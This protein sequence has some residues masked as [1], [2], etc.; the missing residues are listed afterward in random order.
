MDILTLHHYTRTIIHVL[1]A[2]FSTRCR[3]EWDEVSPSLL[4]G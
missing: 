4:D 1:L 3:D 2:A